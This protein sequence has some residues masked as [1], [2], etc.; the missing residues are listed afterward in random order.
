MAG[1]SILHSYADELEKRLRLKTYPL[2][3]KLLE[4]EVDIPEG[5]Q[6]PMK[7]FGYHLLQCQAFAMSRRDGTLIAM[8]KEDMWCCEPVISYGLAEPPQRF[9]DGHNRF[10][11][12]VAT[13]EAARNYVHDLPKFEVGKYLGIASA[14]LAT[15][16]FEPDLV[17]IYCDVT[18]LGLILLGREYKEGF[19]LNCNVSSHAACVYSIVPPMQSGECSV[20]IPCRGE[21]WYAMTGDDELIFAVP[22]GKLEDF[23][24]GLRHCEKWNSKLPKGHVLKPD[25][26]MPESYVEIAE[27]LGMTTKKATTF[28]G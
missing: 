13:L 12:D 20:A 10:P 1:L 19:H 2:A 14:P 23:L 6:R 3:V 11:R 27:L 5:A 9:I 24:I 18:Q 8:L 7:D 16:N 17:L 21:H 22:K 15:A 28:K 25:P 26:Q 4:R